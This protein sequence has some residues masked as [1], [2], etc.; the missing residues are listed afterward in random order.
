MTIELSWMY[1]KMEDITMN[2]LVKKYRMVE[3]LGSLCRSISL[4]AVLLLGL[5]NFSFAESRGSSILELSIW[6]QGPFEVVLNNRT[7]RGREVLR[8]SDLSPGTHFIEV[9]QRIQNSYSNRGAGV[10][11]VY[12]GKITIPAQRK[13]KA[14][15]TRNRSIRV[16]G[17]ERLRPTPI[18]TC[19][20]G[21]VNCQ[22][23]DNHGA[24]GNQYRPISN[25]GDNCSCG[26]NGC[27][28]NVLR[29]VCGP[30]DLPGNGWDNPYD[31]SGHDDWD[32]HNHDGYNDYGN[33]D[34]SN[35]NV[36]NNQDFSI[37][38]QQLDD[39]YFD[40]QRMI[41]ARQAIG[42]NRINTDQVIA[43]LNTFNFESTKLEFAKFAYQKVVDP[44]R[45]YLVNESFSFS[46]SIRELDDFIA[47]N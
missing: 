2:V 17:S 7:Y 19:S 22:M 16:L 15:I 38:L 33:N 8:V 46:S 40:D 4:F 30:V 32:N 42:Q 20:C 24:V 31:N 23:H 45:Y 44:Q 9:N 3:K 41:I 35:Y 36:M 10:R 39:N 26:Q 43:I 1:P 34:Y 6:N 18:Q 27:G 14:Q 37:L 29:P 21:Q 12:R 25:H 5:V 28:S 13:L 47:S 11:N